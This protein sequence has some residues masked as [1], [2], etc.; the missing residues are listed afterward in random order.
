MIYNL[1]LD[2]DIDLVF[3]ILQFQN[4]VGTDT[5]DTI[6]LNVCIY[7]SDYY[8]W[9][10]FISV[11]LHSCYPQRAVLIIYGDLQTGICNVFV[12]SDSTFYA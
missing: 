2:S 10:C 6:M 1:V 3:F 8:M 4:L 5:I 12:V 11:S 7:A 9:Q